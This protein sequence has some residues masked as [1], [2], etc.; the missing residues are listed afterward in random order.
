LLTGLALGLH[1]I[2]AKQKFVIFVAIMPVLA[3]TAN[4]LRIVSLTGL[5]LTYGVKTANGVWHG[6]TGLFVLLM[7]LV[8]AKLFANFLGDHSKKSIRKTKVT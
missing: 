4:F 6:L 7:T 2:R 8:I 5:C 1:D 3:W